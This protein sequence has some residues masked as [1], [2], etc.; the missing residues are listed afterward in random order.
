MLL[1]GLTI[2]AAKGG[3]GLFAAVQRARDRQ[4]VRQLPQLSDVGVERPARPARSRVG[5]EEHLAG[6]AD[7]AAIVAADIPS[8]RLVADLLISA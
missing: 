4:P 2:V 3:L 6:N 1:D 8:L 7:Q 5:F